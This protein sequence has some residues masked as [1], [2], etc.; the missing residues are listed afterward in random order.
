MK[1]EKLTGVFLQRAEPMLESM[2]SPQSLQY[3]GY[4]I[5]PTFTFHQKIANVMNAIIF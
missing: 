3:L 5:F 2:L 4:Q 1:A